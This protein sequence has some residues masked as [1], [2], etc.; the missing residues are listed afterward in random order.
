MTAPLRAGVVGVGSL[1]FHHARILREVEGVQMAGVY[2]GNPERAAKVA[3]DLGVRAF[4]SL[5]EFLSNVDAAVVAVTTTS[6]A[7][8]AIPALERGVHLLIE[9]PIASTLEEAERIVDLA[10]AKGAV[11][12]TGHVERF[13]GA[14]RACEQYL[15]EPK[16]VESHRLSPFNPRGTDVAV[17]LDLM[18]HDIDLVLGLVG[19]KVDRVDAVGVPVLTGS[20]DIANARL[21]FEGGA[22][23][24]ITASRVSFEK[25][26]KIRFFQKSGYISLDLATGTGE[27]LR[28]K[29]G[30]TMPEGDFSLLSLMSI[31]ERVELK[32]D[33]AEPLRA[34]LEAWSAAVRGTGP[35]VVSGEDGRDALA[36][37]LEIMNRIEQSAAA[38]IAA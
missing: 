7:E 38:G 13:N 30:A 5:D 28:L 1:G 31:V 29:K 16:F 36:I 37:A 27:F 19:R 25:M 21:V 6:H 22:V 4:G 17:V 23:A 3:A 32:G 9:K 8:V 35:L 15:E 33:G 2:D 24:N 10:K 12:A 34:E 26:R 20:A 14:L 18:I 11:V